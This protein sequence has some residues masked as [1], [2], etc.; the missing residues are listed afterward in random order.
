MAVEPR[1]AGAS[2]FSEETVWDRSDANECGEARALTALSPLKWWGRHWLRSYFTLRRSFPRFGE[3]LARPLR[4]LS[5]IHFGRW[6]IIDAPSPNPG[7]PKE[8]LGYGYL[9][10]ESNFNGRWDQ[11]IDAF[12]YVLGWRMGLIWKSS[13]GFPGA[14]PAESFK[15]YIRSSEYDACHYYSAY[16][17]A[18]VSTICSALTLDEPLAELAQAARLLDPETFRRRYRTFLTRF[19]RHL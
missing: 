8:E 16:P 1:E 19:Q 18:T 2:R 17:D 6:S 13:F 15:A 5:F 3:R 11:Y 14:K 7:A 12:S 9:L 4:R 10:F